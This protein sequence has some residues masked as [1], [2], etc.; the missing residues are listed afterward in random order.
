MLPL[1]LL[2]STF[3]YQLPYRTKYTYLLELPMYWLNKYLV[4]FS[5]QPHDRD[6]NLFTIREP[7]YLTY[8]IPLDTSYLWYS[9]Y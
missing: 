9:L 3:R 5:Y 7:Y 6:L 4:T 1:D 8:R 2:I